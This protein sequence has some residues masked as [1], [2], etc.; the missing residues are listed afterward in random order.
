MH[1]NAACGRGPRHRRG[2]DREGTT[3]R[4]LVANRPALRRARAF[5]ASSNWPS[6]SA[7][8]PAGHPRRA[9]RARLRCGARAAV[10]QLQR[11]AAAAAA[12]LLTRRQAA[13]RPHL[14]IPELGAAD[15]H[16]SRS[17]RKRYSRALDGSRNAARSPFP[18]LP[19]CA[20]AAES[21]WR[22][23]VW[24]EA[25]H[26][27]RLLIWYAVAVSLGFLPSALARGC[28]GG[29]HGPG[30]RA[31]GF[32][33]ADVPLAHCRRLQSRP[34][35]RAAACACTPLAVCAAAQT[36]HSRRRATQVSVVRRARGARVSPGACRDA[37]QRCKQ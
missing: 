7:G 8:R 5:P 19:T 12:R 33:R 22:A 16:T 23:M 6:P 34:L 37:A 2:R 1:V 18:A 27:R 36:T 28:R 9:A 31:N 11:G 20:P 24:R 17:R 4:R 32:T 3:T 35:W 21:V 26:E 14:L 29:A 10:G 13:A 25:R 15:A 30:A